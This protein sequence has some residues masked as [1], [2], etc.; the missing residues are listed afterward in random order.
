MALIIGT[1]LALFSLGVAVYP[2]LRR[3]RDGR[4]G[5]GSAQDD[6]DGLPAAGAGGAAAAGPDSID[7]VYDAIRT[8]QLEREL[9]NIPEG[10]YR[11]QLADYRRQAALALRQQAMAQV[12]A[13]AEVSDTEPDNEPDNEEDAALEEEIRLARAG[14]EAA[15]PEPDSTPEPAP[16]PQSPPEIDRQGKD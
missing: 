14:L 2:F 8:L 12:Q 13:P 11:E 6:R 9:G 15:S 1:I 10:L 4:D 3:R 16:E 7:S 5:A